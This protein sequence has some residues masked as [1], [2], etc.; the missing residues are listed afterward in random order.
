[1]SLYSQI[2][3]DMRIIDRAIL[4]GVDGEADAYAESEWEDI[5]RRIIALARSTERET[6]CRK[7]MDRA[8]KLAYKRGDDP[9]D[10][11]ETARVEAEKDCEK[12][13]AH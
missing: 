5:K 2:K 9:V 6:H 8:E 10:A 11:R 1:M 12:K 4:I 3:S 7:A 13:H